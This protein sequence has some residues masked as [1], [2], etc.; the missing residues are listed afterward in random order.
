MN[1]SPTFSKNV[2]I[3]FFAGKRETFLVCRNL[4]A[5]LREK[6]L[7]KTI[8][9][10]LEE[11]SLQAIHK[12]LATPNTFSDI[13]LLLKELPKILP[14]DYPVVEDIRKACLWILPQIKLA[15]QRNANK[16]ET[17]GAWRD[18][19]EFDYLLDLVKTFDDYVHI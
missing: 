3:D 7:E 2:P 13:R 10:A 6:T 8:A 16:A 4:A 15:M 18:F 17:L 19:T 9:D 14:L 5:F 1:L 11:S 12:A